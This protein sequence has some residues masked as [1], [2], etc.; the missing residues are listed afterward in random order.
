MMST[1]A[2]AAEAPVDGSDVGILRCLVR[3]AS[4]SDPTRLKALMAQ[5]PIER[6]R[7]MVAGPLG[8][9]F[10]EQLCQ[11]LVAADASRSVPLLEAVYIRDYQALRQR[12]S[13]DE[14]D[15]GVL[16]RAAQVLSP[17]HICASVVRD[18]RRRLAEG[19]MRRG[20]LCFDAYQASFAPSPKTLARMCMQGLITA[21]QYVGQPNIDADYTYA[22]V[23]AKKLPFTALL[24]DSPDCLGRARALVRAGLGKW[25]S[26]LGQVH[27]S[28][29]VLA[30]G[31]AA[32][33]FTPDMVHAGGQ[34]LL[35][36]FWRQHKMPPDAIAHAAATLWQSDEPMPAYLV[37]YVRSAADINELL[38]TLY[39]PRWGVLDA[40][41]VYVARCLSLYV[42]MGENPVQPLAK[43]RYPTA[44][45]AS[46]F[47]QQ[48]W[49][50]VRLQSAPAAAHGPRAAGFCE[51]ELV[52]VPRAC[53][54]CGDAF[55]PDNPRFKLERCAHAATFDKACL[56]RGLQSNGGHKCP[57]PG[58]TINICAEDLL[59]QEIRGA[60][61]D[62]LPE[63]TLS[64]WQA[65]QPLW[66][67]C[68]SVGC[69]NGRILEPDTRERL[70]CSCCGTSSILSTRQP[71]FSVLN[72]EEKKQV[73]MLINHAVVPSGLLARGRFGCLRYLVRECYH[74]GVATQ[75]DGGCSHMNCSQCNGRW[76][77]I[78]GE[79]GAYQYPRIEQLYVPKTGLLLD[80][81][82]YCGLRPGAVYP[83]GEVSQT[84]RRN[85]AVAEA[86]LD[87]ALLWEQPPSP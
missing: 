28:D 31:V 44:Q 74:C 4:L 21:E 1:Q 29:A 39:M 78:N 49:Q 25:E 36:V 51:L 55:G 32:G 42:Q 80:L 15:V 48:V 63:R 69:P 20:T 23:R 71:I 84:L 10:I 58:C 68:S 77:F 75:H 34:R 73:Y 13:V 11:E 26:W 57:T 56:L 87:A 40:N 64:L 33:D 83:P 46:A 59:Q 79:L 17:P 12:P 70:D 52:D 85:L 67:P 76:D 7:D 14:Q 9:V 30:A 19:L 24:F 18:K 37:A 38:E 43:R 5:L 16:Q 50:R 86:E 66:R 53:M 72:E 22:L 2:S 6:H 54:A 47:V 81:G 27:I 61:V 3:W 8:Q 35:R 41:R 45:A 82:L 60:W 65:K 62:S